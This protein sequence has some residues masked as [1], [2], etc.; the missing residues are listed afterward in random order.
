MPRLILVFAGCTDH[1][2]GL[3][4]MWPGWTTFIQGLDST[5]VKTLA[6]Y[7]CGT[8]SIFGAEKWQVSGLLR[9]LH[10]LPPCTTTECQHLHLQ[11]CV[12]IKVEMCFLC[13]QSKIGF[14]LLQKLEVPGGVY[15]T[16]SGAIT[17]QNGLIV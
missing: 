3:V 8:G 14:K 15:I 7:H 13:N 10:F 5:G 11:E 16:P 12:C 17:Y 6:C 9:V 2:V 4:T 1:F